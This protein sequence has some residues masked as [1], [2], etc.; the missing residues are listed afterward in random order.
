MAVQVDETGRDDPV[1][2]I[3][4][5]PDVGRQRRVG[6][7]DPQPL[8]VD[9]DTPRS[10]G[11]AG[12]IDDRPAADQEVRSCRHALTIAEGRHGPRCPAR[13]S[14]SHR[15]TLPAGDRPMSG[16][17]GVDLVTRRNDG[18]LNAVERPPDRRYE[19]LVQRRP[20]SVRAAHPD[21]LV[22]CPLENDQWTGAIGWPEP[23]SHGSAPNHARRA[24]PPAC[25]WPSVGR[26]G[27]TFPIAAIPDRTVPRPERDGRPARPH[28]RGRRPGRPRPGLSRRRPPQGRRPDPTVGSIPSTVTG[29][30]DVPNRGP[31]AD[32]RRSA[33]LGRL[34]RWTVGPH[35]RDKGSGRRGRDTDRRSSGA[36]PP[37]RPQ[38]AGWRRG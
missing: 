1:G 33:S 11:R 4:A 28:R 20:I 36:E 27:R 26:R 17:P 14:G 7:E 23:I 19:H 8:P 3:D 13:G 37:T 38:D 5:A 18:P 15:V 25:P 24:S 30:P 35:W 12:P 10:P 31:A 29:Q 16:R 21:R 32:R 2:G 34:D 22:S 6:R 9:D